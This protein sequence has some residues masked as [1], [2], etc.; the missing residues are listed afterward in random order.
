MSDTASPRP[1]VHPRAREQLR[2]SVDGDE[3]AAIREVWKRHSIAE[4]ARDLDGLISTLTDDCVYELVDTGHRWEGH[5]GAR[6]FYTEFL[7]A[8]PDVEF[9]L[10][11]IVIGPQGVCEIADAAGTHQQDFAGRPASGRR[12]QWRVVIVFPW[13]PQ[14]R[15]FAGERVLSLWGDTP[16]TEQVP[17][18]DVAEATGGNMAYD[19]VEG[20]DRD[21]IGRGEVGDA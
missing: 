14:R 3:Y 21:A 11:D 17:A 9:F 5:D 13:D 12:E 2:R 16:G 6:R 10:Q 1:Q 8:F 15:L 7:G 20:L 19:E 18:T 4:D